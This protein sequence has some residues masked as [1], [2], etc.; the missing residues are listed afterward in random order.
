MLYSQSNSSNES[1]KKD[2][3]QTDGRIK[4]TT[5]GYSHRPIVT[6]TEQPALLQTS[7]FG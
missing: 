3:I 7:L 6:A 2:K 1:V 5:T 4:L